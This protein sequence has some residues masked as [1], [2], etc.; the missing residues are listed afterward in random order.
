MGDHDITFNTLGT[1]RA[2]AKTAENFRK[3]DLYMVRD[4]AILS[5]KAAIKHFSLCSSSG[6]NANL[7]A[8]DWKITHGLLYLKVKGQAEN[9]VIEQKINRVSIFRPGFLARD[10][11]TDGG[12]TTKLDVKYLA[13]VMVYDAEC[14]DVDDEK[15]EKTVFYDGAMIAALSDV[16]ARNAGIKK[17]EVKEENNDEVKEEI[18]KKE[19]N[20]DKDKEE[21][22]KEKIV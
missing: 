11:N 7:W 3:V 14:E 18:E 2:I 17:T 20:A 9:A 22:P 6:A 13:A 12:I 1:K 5:K 10:G 21:E 15:M 8:N 19:P 4:S 16:A